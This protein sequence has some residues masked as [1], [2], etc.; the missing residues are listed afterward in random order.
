MEKNAVNEWKSRASED[1]TNNQQDWERNEL[2][3]T[4]LAPPVR[5]K[6]NFVLMGNALTFYPISIGKHACE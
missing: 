6:W 4:P 3:G 1:M 5:E 2:T